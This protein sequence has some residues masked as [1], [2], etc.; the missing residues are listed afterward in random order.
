MAETPVMSDRAVA[1]FAFAL[2]HQ[3]ESGSRVT[4]VVREDESGHHADDAAVRELEAVGLVTSENGRI[5]FTE[6]GEKVLDR[7]LAAM[8]EAAVLQN[9]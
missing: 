5:T 3:L 2:Y 4:Q 8:R 6:T 1:V 9:A 7:V